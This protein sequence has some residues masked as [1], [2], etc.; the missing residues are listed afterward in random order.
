MNTPLV[1]LKR[2]YKSIRGEI[3]TAV[4]SVLK[5]ANFILGQQVDIFEKEFA[6]FCNTGYCVGVA[7]GSD[8]IFLSLKALDI[9]KNDEVITVAN[10][11]ISTV[12]PIL[13]LDATPILVDINPETY[14]ID[15]DLLEKAISKK[16]RA[17]LAV[18]LYGI[19]APMEEIMK[20]AEK[21]NLKVIED[22][23]QAHGSSI[24]GKRCGSFGDLAA[25][26]FYPGKNLGAAGDG[27]AV[28]TSD[29]ALFEKIR[30]MRNIGQSQ[31]YRHEVFGLNS[32]LDTLQAAILSVKLKHL[33]AWNDSRRKLAQHYD[34]YLAGL[35]IKL[36]PKATKASLSNF[37]LYVIRTDK[38]DSLLE[39][40]KQKGVFAGIHYPIPLHLQKSLVSLGYKKGDFPITEEYA[41]Q[42]LSLPLFP[43]LTIK[44]VSQIA[45]LISAFFKIK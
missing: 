9:Q 32:R 37:H 19:P 23:C 25:F 18:H 38:R 42:V 22:A 1:D 39:F 6:K 44:E 8:A 29:K 45:R 30:I 36:P 16:T 26:S 11:F 15:V 21:Y 24:N 20:L 14:Q 3:N 17:I 12:F 43:E 7:S 27:G 31:K 41:S 35:P 2:Q 4:L 10:T 5:E 34:R 33:N 13:M 28:L 40:L